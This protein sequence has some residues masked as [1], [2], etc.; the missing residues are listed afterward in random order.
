V[1]ETL[2]APVAS[3]HVSH[4]RNPNIRRDNQR[5]DWWQW[6]LDFGNADLLENWNKGVGVV[7]A[8][9]GAALAAP[10]A[11]AQKGSVAANIALRPLQVIGSWLRSLG[12]LLGMKSVSPTVQAVVSLGN[13][14]GIA[15]GLKVEGHR[16]DWPPGTPVEE[17]IEWLRDAYRHLEAALREAGESND[18]EHVKIRAE[19]EANVTAIAQDIEALKV[20]ILEENEKAVQVQAIGLLPIALGIVLSGVPEFLASLG[21]FGWCLVVVAIT[22]TIFAIRESVRH[23]IWEA[24][25]K[26]A[27]KPK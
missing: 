10:K 5:M 6:F 1:H 8:L 9:I 2:T 22:V 24:D 23:D 21:F 15:D 17:R 27:A 14:M 25:A 7:I 3:D 18:A 16:G 4:H 13:G 26:A 12:R 19:L 11:T 20:F